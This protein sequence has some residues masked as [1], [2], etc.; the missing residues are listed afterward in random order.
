M[1]T[2]QHTE[3]LAGGTDLMERRRSGVAPLAPVVL[4]ITDD[5]R[6]IS[7]LPDGGVRI[8]A[9]V[10]IDTLARDA[11]MVIAY[12]GLVAAAA[13]LA[14]P[15]IRRM[16][17]VGGNLTQ[18]SRCWYFRNHWTPCLKKGGST[19]PA[20]SGNHLYGVAFDL[21]PC[22]APHPSTLGAAFLA[23]DAAIETSERRLSVPALFGDG[24][25]GASDHQLADG[26]LVRAIELPAPR[27][28]ELAHYG[29]AIGRE[30]AEWP[31]VET[32]VRVVIADAR[33]AFAAVALGGVA[34]IPLR[35]KVLEDKL[36]GLDP[37][38]QDPFV[39]AA[40]ATE[41][42]VPLAQT[43]YKLSL[44]RG[45]VADALTRVFAE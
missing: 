33:V 5:M 38:Q 36:R 12:P 16:A 32:V 17:T 19:C 30:H 15:E 6:A 8:G 23:Y 43:G 34:P 44:V 29:R 25:D 42:A 3:F 40:L 31:L 24:R 37:T 9:A 21:G 26:E 39:L 18:R 11:R 28:G 4:P 41:G 10:T 13:G 2:K 22:V 27:V 7:W 1:A 35:L 20:R 14:T 45:L